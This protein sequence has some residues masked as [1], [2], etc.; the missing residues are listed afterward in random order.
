VASK[1][2]RPTSSCQVQPAFDVDGHLLTTSGREIGSTRS[3]ARKPV[4][5]R[6]SP[7]SQY[8][9]PLARE[10]TYFTTCRP[11]GTPVHPVGFE[12]RVV[13]HAVLLSG[14]SARSTEVLA[15]RGW[16]TTRRFPVIRLALARGTR[17]SSERPLLRSAP[18]NNSRSM[19][20]RA[21]TLTGRLEYETVWI[22]G[23]R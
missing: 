7:V 11:A 22:N 8:A 14:H 3:G 17:G 6:Y 23:G 21:A 18:G 10:A 13:N 12:R 16:V 9:G 19:A 5:L 1:F 4:A 2:A 20:S 15:R